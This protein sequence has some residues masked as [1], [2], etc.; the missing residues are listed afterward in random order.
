MF[1]VPVSQYGNMRIE[2]GETLATVFGG[3]VRIEKKPRFKSR[4]RW[5]SQTGHFSLHNLTVA[6]SGSYVIENT[7]GL[8]GKYTFRLNV[9]GKCSFLNY[10]HSCTYILSNIYASTQ[11][12]SSHIR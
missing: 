7:E 8:K 3:R 5:D 11:I 2:G 1:P 12:K 9:Y 6:D 4:L 10:A